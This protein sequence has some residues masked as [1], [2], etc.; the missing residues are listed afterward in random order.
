MDSLIDIYLSYNNR[1]EVLRLPIFPM[2]FSLGN[3]S[4]NEVFNSITIGEIQLLGLRG[5]STITFSSYFPDNEYAFTRNNSV[6]S[7]DYVRIIEGW[8]N[9]KAPIRLVITDTLVNMACTIDSFEYGIKDST[10]DLYYSLSLTEFKFI[11]LQEVK[12]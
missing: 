2:D 6:Y 8:L 9:K 11:K 4:K 10:G 5:L 12:K 3:S 1:E 7:W